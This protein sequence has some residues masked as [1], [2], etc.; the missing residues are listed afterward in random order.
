MKTARPIAGA[1]PSRELRKG[2][3]KGAAIDAGTVEALNDPV[4][5]RGV[6]RLLP[7]NAGTAAFQPLG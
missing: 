1:A 4:H 5:A 6:H 7:Q 3:I 2:S